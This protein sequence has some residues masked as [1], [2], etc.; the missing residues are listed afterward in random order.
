MQMDIGYDGRI[1]YKKI[2]YT[3]SQD[4]SK[5]A[6]VEVDG[7]LYVNADCPDVTF[8]VK[9]TANCDE[10]GGDDVT[11]VLAEHQQDLD[12]QLYSEEQ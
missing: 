1:R 5:Y 8:T 9:I 10:N 11:N 2:T 12:G 6:V 7:R 3:K 4:I